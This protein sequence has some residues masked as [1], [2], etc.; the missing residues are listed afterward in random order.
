MNTV[1]L[2]AHSLFYSWFSLNRHNNPSSA[3][4]TVKSQ[5]PQDSITWPSLYYMLSYS[6]SHSSY[7]N[8]QNDLHTFDNARLWCSSSICCKSNMTGIYIS[9]NKGMKIIL[10]IHVGG[11]G[12]IICQCGIEW[13]PS[14]GVLASGWGE[15]LLTVTA[16]DDRPLW[17]FNENQL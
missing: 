3:A 2:S 13:P 14:D 16:A 15:R 8:S 5:S 4:V 7:K 17:R 11:M 12:E 6:L 9:E 10:R 1:I